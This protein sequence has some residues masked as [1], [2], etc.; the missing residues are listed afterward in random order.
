[1]TVLRADVKARCNIGG[2]HLFFLYSP[3]PV[4]SMTGRHISLL[5]EQFNH[6]NRSNDKM[7]KHHLLSY[8]HTRLSRQISVG[9]NLVVLQTTLSL[10]KA[11]IFSPTEL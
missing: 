8:S 2:N 1:M 6:P 10:Q 7:H 11:A 3:T 4:K 9:T 5:L